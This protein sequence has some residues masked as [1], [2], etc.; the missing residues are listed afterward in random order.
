M[1]SICIS[2]FIS[3]EFCV[4]KLRF[5]LFVCYLHYFSQCPL[6]LLTF[7]CSVC[8][9]GDFP[10]IHC[11]SFIQMRTKKNRRFFLIFRCSG[12]RCNDLDS[13]SNLS[14]FLRL[15]FFISSS[16]SNQNGL[17]LQTLYQMCN[18][19]IAM[20]SGQSE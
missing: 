13:Y 19:T 16:R 15:F 20:R 11:Y 8:L 4:P 3:I 18:V 6:N 17:Q 9:L 2:I 14:L 12:N 7:S 1:N 10:K 5:F